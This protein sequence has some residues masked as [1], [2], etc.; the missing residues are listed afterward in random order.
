MYKNVEQ[1][2]F[3]FATVGIANHSRK[4]FY[5]SKSGCFQ[6]NDFNNIIV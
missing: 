4:F 2:I 3:L 5:D 6:N 1:S